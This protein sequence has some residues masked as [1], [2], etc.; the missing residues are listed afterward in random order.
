MTFEQAAALPVAGLTALQGLRDVGG[1]RAGQHVLIIGASGG[2]GTL[3]VQIA[4]ALGAQVTAVCS[5]PNVETAWAIGADQVVDYKKEDF[6]RTDERYDLIFDGPVNRS[7][8]KYKRLLKPAGVYVMFGGPKRRVVGPLPRLLRTKL[9]F[10][11]GKRRMGWFIAHMNQDD[12][13]FLAGLI[14]S[15][16]VSRS[17]RRPINWI[18]YPR[19][20]ATRESPFQREGCHH[21]LRSG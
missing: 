7:I 11:F 18:K 15:G 6:T 17:W 14:D 19:R 8:S 10:I 2:V 5:T 9:A 13:S 16:D 3:A 1:L 4:K 20:W 21:S 12:L